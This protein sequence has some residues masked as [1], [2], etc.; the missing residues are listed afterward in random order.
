MK[1]RRSPSSQTLVLSCPCGLL[2]PLEVG[3][4]Y[5]HTCDESRITFHVEVTNTHFE[6]TTGEKN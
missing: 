4:D 3:V 2:L 6:I 5:M 1:V